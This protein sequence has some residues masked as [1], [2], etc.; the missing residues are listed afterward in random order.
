MPIIYQ[1]DRQISIKER[2]V[3]FK[4]IY[5]AQCFEFYTYEKNPT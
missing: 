3:F 4:V 1:Y 2:V 5:N